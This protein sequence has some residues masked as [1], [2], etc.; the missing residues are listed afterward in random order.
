MKLTVREA[1]W[2]IRSDST[3]FRMR[4]DIHK[5]GFLVSDRLSPEDACK[6]WGNFVVDAIYPQDSSMVTLV[7]TDEEVN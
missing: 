2:L 5:G 4:F 6:K 1:T 3:A 7:I